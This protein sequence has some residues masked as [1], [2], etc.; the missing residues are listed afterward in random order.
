MVLQGLNWHK[1]F[2]NG[3]VSKKYYACAFDYG[4]RVLKD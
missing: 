3:Q 4:A 1:F 2:P